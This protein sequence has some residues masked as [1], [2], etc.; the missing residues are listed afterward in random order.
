MS[1]TFPHLSLREVNLVSCRVWNLRPA[2]LAGVYLLTLTLWGR[3][4]DE[5]TALEGGQSSSDVLAN[6]DEDEPCFVLRSDLRVGETICRDV[7]RNWSL[8]SAGG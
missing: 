1:L 5:A 2:F 6:D 4:L 7:R 8:G 3:L